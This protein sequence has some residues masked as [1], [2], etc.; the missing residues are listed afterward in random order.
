MSKVRHLLFANVLDFS[1][2]RL[3]WRSLSNII[4]TTVRTDRAVNITGHANHLKQ[5]HEQKPELRILTSSVLQMKYQAFFRSS[6]TL[7]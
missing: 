4:R 2:L 7:Q 1:V 5:D 6:S 3:K